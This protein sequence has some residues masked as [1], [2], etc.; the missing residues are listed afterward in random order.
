LSNTGNTS[1]A[2]T[3]GGST[4]TTPVAEENKDGLAYTSNNSNEKSPSL[5]STGRTQPQSL[6]EKLAIEA[7]MSNPKAGRQLPIPM[8]DARW[9]SSDGW[10]KM[11]QN[12]NGIEVHYVRNTKS[13]VVDDFKFK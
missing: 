5:G 1:G 2:I 13:G 7:A 3:A 11:S 12:I 10:V 4:T 8:S 9:P 6:A